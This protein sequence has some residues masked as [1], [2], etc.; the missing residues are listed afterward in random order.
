MGVR[1]VLR[2]LLALVNAAERRQPPGP[3]QG[4]VA[5][6]RRAAARGP[7]QMRVVTARGRTPVVTDDHRV[8]VEGGEIG[9]R[10]YRPAGRSGP[11]PTHLFLHGGS[12]WL[13]S[14]DDYDPICFTYAGGADCQVVSVDYRLAPEHPFPTGVEDSYAALL[15]LVAHA[16][17]LDVDLDRLSVGGISAGGGLA[18]A[19]TLMAR[20]RSGPSL[21]FLAVDI[22]SLDLT[23]SQPSIEEFGEGHLLT[24]ASL[25]EA[26]GFY[27]PEPELARHPYASPLLAEDLRGLPP[28]SV[29][30][31]E[32]DP[33]RDEG[34]AYARRLR[35]AGVA[36]STYRAA[37][38]VHGSIYMTRLLPSARAAVAA[39]TG[40][41]RTAL[42]G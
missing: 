35:E 28:A 3:A 17:V 20:D 10:R 12:Y 37:G 18:A 24:R 13:S 5:E 39:T 42:H 11:L 32:C 29:L 6:R 26:V 38:H 41:L 33:L 2:P 4:S 30:T 25:V 8:P 19:L 31:C 40:A 14:V 34:E 21:C 9:V 23:L 1:P 36:V 27:L 16:A 15:W 22:P 7:Q